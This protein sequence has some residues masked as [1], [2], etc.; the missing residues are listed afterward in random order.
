MNIYVTMINSVWGETSVLSRKEGNSDRRRYGVKSW[1]L[2]VPG[3]SAG[4]TGTDLLL[5]G[6]AHLRPV[7]AY[8]F[9]LC[10]KVSVYNQH[11]LTALVIVY[12]VKWVC[13]MYIVLSVLIFY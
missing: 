10:W 8:C 3:G 13:I 4:W 5:C 9:P 1:R 12:G 7:G 2:A 6:R 11:V